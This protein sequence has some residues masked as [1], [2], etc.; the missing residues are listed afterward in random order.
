MCLIAV[1]SVGNETKHTDTV[2][3]IKQYSQRQTSVSASDIG[4]FCLDIVTLDVENFTRITFRTLNN[5]MFCNFSPEQ[6]IM[7]NSFRNRLHN[8]LL[9]N[10]YQAC[11]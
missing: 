8:I 7:N 4:I 3:K 9:I 6:R 11:M 1:T 5:D 2:Q 10:Y